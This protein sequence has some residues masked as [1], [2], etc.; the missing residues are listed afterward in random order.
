M[1]ID[2]YPFSAERAVLFIYGTSPEQAAIPSEIKILKD[3]TGDAAYKNRA[4]AKSQT[5]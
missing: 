2:V 1:E 4:L 5:L 3:V